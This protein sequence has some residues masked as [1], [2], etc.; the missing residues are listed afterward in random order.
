MTHD[1]LI[2]AF[3][4]KIDKRGDDECW[5]WTGACD[6]RGGYGLFGTKKISKST[7]AHRISWELANGPIPTGLCVCHKCDNPPCQNVKHMFLGT[8]ADNVEDKVNKHR[9]LKGEE[10]YNAKLTEEGVVRLFELNQQ[11]LTHTQIEKVT[12]VPATTVCRVL[13]GEDWKHVQTPYRYLVK[14]NNSLPP[15]VVVNIFKRYFELRSMTRVADELGLGDG[16]VYSVLRRHTHIDVEVPP[17]YIVEI[18]PQTK[19]TE[20]DIVAI[21]RLKSLGFS[22]KEIAKQYDLHIGNVHMILRR[23][24]WKNVPIPEKYLTTLTPQLKDGTNG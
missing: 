1:E 8:N 5:L 7:K 10:F 23:D 17:E 22:P 6:R 21:F 11:G 19:L 3:W 9:Q 2:E 20:Q 18:K 13:R 15:D 14:D 12:G 24:T 4:A 16:T